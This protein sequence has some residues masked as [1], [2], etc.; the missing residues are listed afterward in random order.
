MNN[1][2]EK[3]IDSLAMI[4]R[5]RQ[6]INFT[7]YHLSRAENFAQRIKMLEDELATERARLDWLENKGWLE[8][9][10]DGWLCGAMCRVGVSNKSARA[11]IDAAMK[12]GAK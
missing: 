12:E 9:T 3:V 6:R 5:E 10:T 2:I 8:K 4:Q 1:E 7:E 11:A